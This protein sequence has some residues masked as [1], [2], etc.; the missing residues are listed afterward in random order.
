[1]VEENK[2]EILELNSLYV[3]RNTE[4]DETIWLTSNRIRSRVSSNDVAG[5]EASFVSTLPC[6]KQRWC[7]GAGRR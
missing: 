5:T 2:N 3:F 7:L 1:M 4:N 6:E